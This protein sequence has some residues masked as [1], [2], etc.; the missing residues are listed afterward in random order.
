MTLQANSTHVIYKN[1]VKMHNNSEDGISR[2][3][4]VE[5]EFSCI[6]EK[7]DDSSLTFRIHDR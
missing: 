5:I 7:P 1:H 2:D 4:K 6:N 3:G